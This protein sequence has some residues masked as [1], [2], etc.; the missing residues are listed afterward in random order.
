MKFLILSY[1]GNRL[2]F[3]LLFQNFFILF[4][5]SLIL[6]GILTI[7]FATLFYIAVI[8][9]WT[10]IYFQFI[11]QILSDGEPMEEVFDKLFDVGFW[12]YLKFLKSILFFI[13]RKVFENKDI[14][15]V[16][17]IPN[18]FTLYS[19]KDL[20]LNCVKALFILLVL[21]F[22]IVLILLFAIDIYY[23]VVLRVAFSIRIGNV[24]FF[25]WLCII[26]LFFFIFV[27]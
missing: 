6:V 22:L 26:H 25:F 8:Y 20:F 2:Q 18:W 5:F 3:V 27:E 9:L 16:Y 10:I 12:E 24:L 11:W 1:Y 13:Q 19:Y 4:Y 15:I 7:F 21:F 14:G 23:F 17:Y